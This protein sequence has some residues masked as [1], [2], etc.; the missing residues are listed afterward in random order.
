[1]AKGKQ[2]PSIAALLPTPSIKSQ[3]VVDIQDG[4][5]SSTPAV[6]DDE[7]HAFSLICQPP[8]S[9]PDVHQ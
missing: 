2:S 6:N 8:K 7:T 5:A 4:G 1:M 9:K 3:G